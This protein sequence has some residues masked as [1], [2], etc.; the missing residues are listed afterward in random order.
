MLLNSL[1]IPWL[2]FVEGFGLSTPDPV[3]MRKALSDMADCGRYT[4]VFC[5]SAL[6]GIIWGNYLS[7]KIVSLQDNKFFCI[8]SELSVRGS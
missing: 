5:L 2:S 7:N 4:K 8:R 1:H 6:L 3:N